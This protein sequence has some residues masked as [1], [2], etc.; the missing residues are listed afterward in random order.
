MLYTLIDDDRRAIE[1]AIALM[2]AQH[3]QAGAL[4][5]DM[6]LPLMLALAANPPSS[7]G[8]GGRAWV[9]ALRAL[10]ECLVSIARMID[11]GR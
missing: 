3:G 10:G 5:G 7:S 6:M 8:V 1:R 9:A 4:A 11:H 2:T